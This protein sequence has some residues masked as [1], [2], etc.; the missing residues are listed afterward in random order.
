MPSILSQDPARPIGVRES[1]FGRNENHQKRQK[2]S[3]VVKSNLVSV[4]VFEG[5][6]L[7]NSGLAD[8]ILIRS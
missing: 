4:L 7:D 2:M 3:V 1:H 5:C 6:L 8:L